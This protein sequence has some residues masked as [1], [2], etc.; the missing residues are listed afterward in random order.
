MLPPLDNLETALDNA[1]KH[2]VHFAPR[3]K[4]LL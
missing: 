2:M 3:T 1:R 4:E